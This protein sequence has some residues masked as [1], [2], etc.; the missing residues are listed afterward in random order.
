MI[1]VGVSVRFF[2]GFAIFFVGFFGRVLLCRGR[3]RLG[4]W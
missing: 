3:D 2:V 1:P 4:V